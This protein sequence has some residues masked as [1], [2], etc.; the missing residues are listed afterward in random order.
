MSFCGAIYLQVLCLSE[1]VVSLFE[2]REKSFSFTYFV[3]SLCK[4]ESL[5]NYKLIP[6]IVWLAWYIWN[7]IWI[8]GEVLGCRVGSGV[9]SCWRILFF[10][11]HV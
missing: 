8:E 11:R 5:P 3:C 7:G 9:F 2:N 6:P 10:V 4:R 1:K